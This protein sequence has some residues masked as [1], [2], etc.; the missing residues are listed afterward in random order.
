MSMWAVWKGMKG[1]SRFNSGLEHKLSITQWCMETVVI[2]SLFVE[3]RSAEIFSNLFHVGL[4]PTVLKDTDPHF[5]G[6]Y[7]T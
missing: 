1:C 2:E 3:D 5:G 6:H 7:V 4:F